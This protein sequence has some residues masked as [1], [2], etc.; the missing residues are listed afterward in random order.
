[1]SSLGTL[2]HPVKVYLCAALMGVE[3]QDFPAG[4]GDGRGIGRPGRPWMTSAELH[5]ALKKLYE[6]ERHFTENGL[7]E[8]LASLQAIGLVCSRLTGGNVPGR[9][10]ALTG[11]GRKRIRSLC[12]ECVSA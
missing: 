1:M 9:E 5:E 6:G 3:F 11:E 10:W 7:E 2:R 12:R 4:N 8:H